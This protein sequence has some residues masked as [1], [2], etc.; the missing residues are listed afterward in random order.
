MSDYKFVLYE[1]LDDGRIARI[2]LN[3]PDARNAQNRG[4][5]V[6]LDDAFLRAEADDEVRVVV[7]G[8]VGPMFSS[9]HDLGSKASLEEYMPG[10]NQH[11]TMTINGGTRKGAESRM[12]QEWH[13]FFEN[14]R[15]WRNLRKITIA[16][17][18]GDVYAAGLMLMWACDLIVCRRRH[19]A[20][21]TWSV[22]GSA[23]AESSTSP[24]RGSSV[25][26]RPRSCCSRATRSM[27]TRPTPS[28][29]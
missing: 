27:P 14:T 3:R 4:L 28:A 19:H 9:G 6:E 13:Y 23:C 7:L 22:P 10:P 21:P 20:S 15:R 24:T 18:H 1:T 17:A 5:L 2:M 26:A 11:P 29:W 25:P 16:Q 12:L 8:G